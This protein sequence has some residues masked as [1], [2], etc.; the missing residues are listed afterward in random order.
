MPDPVHDEQDDSGCRDH[1]ADDGPGRRSEDQGHDQ[2]D[3]AQNGEGQCV[4][5]HELAVVVL[6]LWGTSRCGGSARG[7]FLQLRFQ[8]GLEAGA[9]LA[10]VGA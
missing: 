3:E 8:E 7:E 10:L 5:E 2:G 6:Y 1:Y 4:D 9:V